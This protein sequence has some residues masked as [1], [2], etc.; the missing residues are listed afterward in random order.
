MYFFPQLYIFWL[1]Q[2]CVMCSCACI[3]ACLPAS[4]LTLSLIH[5][6]PE[7]CFWMIINISEDCR[8]PTD[9]LYGARRHITS[10]AFNTCSVDILVF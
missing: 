5:Y 6:Q 10:K 3:N 4:T 1:N 2:Y 9:S 7:D 8:T